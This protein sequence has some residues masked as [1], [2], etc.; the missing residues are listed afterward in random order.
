MNRE[1]TE[2]YLSI[3]SEAWDR[4]EYLDI[5]RATNIAT[6]NCKD[7]W[8]KGESGA[9]V[10]QIVKEFA[11]ERHRSGNYRMGSLTDNSSYISEPQAGQHYDGNAESDD[12]YI[13]MYWRARS[14][15]GSSFDAGMAHIIR[16]YSHTN[17]YRKQYV[18]SVDVGKLSYAIWKALNSKQTKVEK[19]L[20]EFEEKGFEFEEGQK[21]ANL[22]LVAKSFK[23]YVSSFGTSISELICEDPKTGWKYKVRLGAKTQKAYPDLFEYIYDKGWLDKVLTMPEFDGF[24]NINVSGKISKINKE[25]KNVTMNFVTINSPTEEQVKH[26]EEIFRAEFDKAKAKDKAKA[27]AGDDLNTLKICLR[28]MREKP[29]QVDDNFRNFAKLMIDKLR[30]PEIFDSLDEADQQVIKDVEEICGL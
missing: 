12:E 4:Y 9:K 16:E 13:S 5:I 25:F 2:T 11:G 7:P 24:Q 26:W 10:F 21:V 23:N 19:N 27:A 17:P 8:I 18:L 1:F 3:I 28:I 14:Q 29:D 15:S 20:K 30:D 22:E 6:N